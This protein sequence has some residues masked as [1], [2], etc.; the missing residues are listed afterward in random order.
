MLGKNLLDLNAWC[1]STLLYVGCATTP[2]VYTDAYPDKCIGVLSHKQVHEMHLV[3]QQCTK[4]E[5]TLGAAGVRVSNAIY[6]R[7][8]ITW[9]ESLCMNDILRLYY[10]FNCDENKILTES[11]KCFNCMAPSTAYRWYP[12]PHF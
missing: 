1:L 12:G 4:E 5:L 8:M 2:I 6:Q 11:G 10:C 3:V 9:D 7:P